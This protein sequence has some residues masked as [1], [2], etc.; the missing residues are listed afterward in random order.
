MKAALVVLAIAACNAESN[1]VVLVA[2]QPGFGPLVGGTKITLTGGGFT[3]PDHVRVFVGGREAPLVA[4]L[5]DATLDVVIPPGDEAGD[6]ELIVLNTRGNATATGLFRYSTPPS[7]SGVTPAK[8]IPGLAIRMTITGSGFLDEDAGL[9]AVLVDGVPA[10]NVSVASDTVLSCDAPAG[11]LLVRPDVE[12]VNVRGAATKP[13]AF[14]YVPSDRAGLLLFPK[15]G[16]IFA[17]YLD[18]TTNQVINVPRLPTAG[19]LFTAVVRDDAGDYWAIDRNGRFGRI[20]MRMQ[21]IAD[22]LQMGSGFPTMIRLGGEYLALDRSLRRF[23]RVDPLLGVFFP[24]GDSIPCCG[25]YGLASDGTT[26]YFTARSGAPTIIKTLDP[27]TG[28]Q[29]T[30]VPLDVTGFNVH[31]EEMR[32]FAGKLYAASRDGTIRTIDPTTGVTSVLPV[33]INRTGAMELFE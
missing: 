31:V 7:I 21:R 10:G 3:A 12:V 24:R 6:A 29:G 18:P 9:P 5:D 22:P 27:I 19:D 25:S 2:A 11:Q 8:I 33:S 13:S 15:F 26:L 16:P 17:V 32:F 20:D 4:L 28:E 1:G 30:A 23:G 14:R